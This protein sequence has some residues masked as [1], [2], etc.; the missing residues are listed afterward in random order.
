M[1]QNFQN[2]FYTKRSVNN[3]KVQKFV[4]VL[5]ENLNLK[6]APKLSAKY[7]QGKICKIKQMQSIPVTLRTFQNQLK[8]F[9][10]KLIL[11]R[12]YLT[13]LH[14]KF[15]AKFPTER[16]QSNNTTFPWLNFFNLKH[17]NLP[18]LNKVNINMN[19]NTQ[20]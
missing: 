1:T 9:Q 14:L 2:T 8:S 7:L 5:K 19:L 15:S 12:I 17:L 4:P 6:N 20:I 10:K 3:Q 13:L 16:N 11:K 18:H